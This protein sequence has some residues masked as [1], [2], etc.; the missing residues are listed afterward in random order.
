MCIIRTL[1]LSFPRGYLLML[2]ASS[3]QQQ[4]TSE[5]SVEQIVECYFMKEGANKPLQV[6]SI[7]GL[8][9]AAARFIN[10]NDKDAL[11]VLVE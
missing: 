2:I 1:V 6:L 11:Y 8:A 5:R 10:R 3:L 7:K 4:G 9:E